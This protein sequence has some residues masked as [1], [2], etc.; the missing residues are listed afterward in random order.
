MRFY[1]TFVPKEEIF[2]RVMQLVTVE[3]KYI[4]IVD[5]WNFITRLPPICN[6]GKLNTS[7]LFK[8]ILMGHSRLGPINALSPNI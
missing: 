5:R 4:A 3:W 2:I 7:Y 1:D 8:H 6:A